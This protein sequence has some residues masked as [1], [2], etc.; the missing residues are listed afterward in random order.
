M[1]SILEL[2]P[3]FANLRRMASYIFDQDFTHDQSK[4]YYLVGKIIKHLK[5]LYFI[6]MYKI[7]ISKLS[8]A[9]PH[10]YVWRLAKI[11]FI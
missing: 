4:L 3:S 9:Y 10:T 1:Y 8:I 5:L 2:M 11:I 7:F 6:L